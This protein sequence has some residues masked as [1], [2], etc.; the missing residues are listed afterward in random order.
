MKPFIHEDF[1]LRNPTARTL[2]HEY[3]EG[4]PII[5]YHCHLSPKDVCEDRRFSNLYEIWLEGDHYKWR[6][7][8]TNGIPERFCTGDAMPKEKFMAFARTVPYTIRNPMYHWC[9]LELKRVFDCDLIINEANAERI[10]E[11]AAERMADPG[12]SA[13]GLLRQFKVEVVGTTDDPVDDLAWHAKLRDST[14]STGVYP[15]YRPDKAMKTGNPELWNEWVSRLESVSGID[16]S[17]FD[18]FIRALQSR[19][20]VFHEMGARLSDHGL[21]VCPDR[22][23]NDGAAAKLYQQMRAG[24]VPV[25]EDSIG[26]AGNLMLQFGRMDAE[27]GWTKQL[28]LGAMRNTNTRMYGSMG[29]DTG[30]DSVGDWNQALPLAQYLDRLNQE[31]WLPKTVLYNLNP[32]DNYLFATMAGNFQDGTVPGKIQFGSGWWFLDQIEGMTM[33]M[34]ALSNLG[35]LSRF[36]G[37]LTDS[38][39]L[40]SYCRHEYFRRLL[41][42]LIGDDVEKGLI[43]ADIEALGLIVK[44][45]CHENARSYFGFPERS[46]G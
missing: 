34:N 46:R 20:D 15:T 23:L 16:C 1:L 17:A 41:C 36:V 18:G 37:M 39:S 3:A 28:H 21:E 30:F 2:Y 45:I 12:F 19:H 26:F 13:K 42:Q 38:R 9:H 6:L 7:M 4:L 29:P 43:P 25:A 8:R 32:A 14:L 31:G 44:C 24:T 27:K 35:L 10:W 11:I 5:D 33:Q 22:Y 40:L